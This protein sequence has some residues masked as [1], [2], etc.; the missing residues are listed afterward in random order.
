MACWLVSN[1]QWEKG[2]RSA[3]EMKNGEDRNK[4]DA[5]QLIPTGG[6]VKATA[7]M[8][9]RP[10]CRIHGAGLGQ[11]QL[12][13]LLDARKLSS[14]REIVCREKTIRMI[15]APAHTHFN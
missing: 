10:G 6:P 1:N 4:P 9:F 3:Q 2:N 12:Q 14:R 11:E 7:K 13:A 15:L 8:N 5:E